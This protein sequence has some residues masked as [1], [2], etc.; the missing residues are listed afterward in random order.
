MMTNTGNRIT[1]GQFSFLPDLTDE[2]ITAQIKYALKNGWAVSVEYT[3]DPHPRNT[4]WE[5]Y[6]NP[7]FDLQGSRR[8]PAGDQRLPQDVPESLHPRH[9]VR[10]RRAAS[11]VAAHVVHRQPAGE[12]TRLR[13][14]APGRPGPAGSLHGHELCGATSPKAN[15][16]ADG[17]I[18]SRAS[19]ERA[20]RQRSPLP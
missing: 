12:R 10:L 14:D 7:M 17:A 3:D 6:G 11:R 8:D 5:M 19:G 1:Q 2:Q 16:T 18:T 15:A 13:A 9:G 20:R 4:Y